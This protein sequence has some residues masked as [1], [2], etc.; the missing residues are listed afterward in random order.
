M[1]T[2][3]LPESKSIKPES[4]FGWIFGTFLIEMIPFADILPTYTVTAVVLYRKMKR[5]D[6]NIS[7]LDFIL[8]GTLAVM[9]DVL[10]WF[11]VGSI[12]IAGDVL[13]LFV[14]ATTAFWSF[15]RN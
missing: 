5:A 13:D 1:P 7:W 15:M 9:N 14:T 3:T 4:F 8:V 10:D 2:A 11:V 12:P 6:P